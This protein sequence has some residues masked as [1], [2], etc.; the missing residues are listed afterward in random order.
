MQKN[1]LL[2]L[3]LAF[4]LCFSQSSKE[5]E[6]YKSNFFLYPT[7][8]TE[9]ALSSVEKIFKSNQ[10]VDK[11]FAYTAK[12]HLLTISGKYS[13]HIYLPKVNYYLKLVEETPENSKDLS[14]IYNILGNTD[15]ANKNFESALNNFF[16]AEFFAKKNNDVKQIIKVKGNI[17]TVKGNVGLWDDAIKE[18]K[19]TIQFLKNNEKDYDKEYY[20]I[21]LYNQHINLGNWYL[22]KYDDTKSNKKYLDSAK[23]VY[24]SLL[25]QNINPLQKALIYENIGS[26]Y[27][28][29][30]NYTASII[31]YKKAL[32]NFNLAD[33][34]QNLISTNYNI[35]YNYYK[36]EKYDE[37]KKYFRNIISKEKEKS[38]F[39]YLFSH[40]YLAKIYIY[41]ENRDSANYFIDTFLNLYN[42]KTKIEK[43]EF[44]NI[45]KEIEN[46]SLTNE[47]VSIKN[48]NKSLKNFSNAG[49]AIGFILTTF[50]GMFIFYQIKEKKKAKG[51]LDSLL[52]EIEDNKVVATNNFSKVNIKDD[53]EKLIIEGLKKIEENK[54]FLNKEFN[55]HNAAKKIGT[56]T[57]YLT[58]VVKS[59]KNCSFN[60]YTNELRMSYLINEIVN[61][62]KIRNYTIQALAEL[63]GYKNG[64]SFSKIFKEKTGVT[65]F[66]FI[67]KLQ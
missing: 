59:Y 58:I 36:L 53:K 7:I 15:K 21:Q 52:K 41:K 9:K 64:T 46:K 57:T 37:A 50:F 65:P 4:S 39:Q 17:A 60:D 35:A 1:I 14:N 67:E 33:S 18:T 20:R 10:S 23:S 11:A 2:I 56:N 42:K 40:Q 63:V 55:L 12:R 31:N 62:K 48:E 5:I 51:K 47:I 34:N 29:E 13:D 3:L 16:K 32:S 66:Q 28:L 43:K 19:N 54:Y 6:M 38:S 49:I 8:G 61:D 30:N 45:Y 22:Q 24:N 25:N 26:I 27:S 44:A